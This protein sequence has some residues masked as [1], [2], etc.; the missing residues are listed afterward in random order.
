MTH[1]IAR[2]I[3]HAATL[4][5]LV[6][7]PIDDAE[8]S[9][10]LGIKVN[11]NNAAVAVGSGRFMRRE[12]V[13]LEADLEQ[14][15]Q[16]VEARGHSFVYVAVD[17]GLCGAIEL[18]PTVRPEAQAVIKALRERG[19]SVRILSGDAQGP[20]RELAATLGV[21]GFVAEALPETKG[22][23]IADLQASGRRVCFVGDGINDSI[24][25]KRAAVSIAIR[26]ASD[27]AL[28]T[29]QIV[30][31]EKDL[32]HLLTAFD[33]ADRLRSHQHWS[34]GATIVAPSVACMAGAMFF[35]MSL[36]VKMSVFAA[37]AASGTAAAYLPLLRSSQGTRGPRGQWGR[38]GLAD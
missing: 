16:A 7:S 25:L 14:T 30:L 18:R 32:S 13:A 22:K 36:A 23:F 31:L 20:V 28:D 24:A 10:G 9:I 2:A 21:D 1:P 11:A 33:L 4:E 12:G 19:L 37:S 38:V 35:G 8:Y 3:L 5:G 34:I 26:D 17:G 29:A 27:L 15:E 6:P